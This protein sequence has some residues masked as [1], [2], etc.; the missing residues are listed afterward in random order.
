VLAIMSKWKTVEEICAR[1]QRRSRQEMAGLKK[2]ERRMS[3]DE[4]RFTLMKGPRPAPAGRATRTTNYLLYIGHDCGAAGVSVWPSIADV[5]ANL[6]GL[7]ADLLKP[8]NP[9]PPPAASFAAGL[10][11]IG[12][13]DCRIIAFSAGGSTNVWFNPFNE[14]ARS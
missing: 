1:E 6:G 5:E 12:I 8:G 7:T 13:V 2:G 9:F 4:K 14:E 3:D 10:M 11:K